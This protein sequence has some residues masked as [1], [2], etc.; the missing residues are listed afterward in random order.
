MRGRK[1]LRGLVRA[2][3]F[4][5]L[6]LVLMI[7]VLWWKADWD[8]R[9]LLRVLAHRESSTTDFRWK[10]SVTVRPSDT[11]IPW[12]EVPGCPHVDRAFA[13]ESDVETMDDYLR[14][15]GTTA[16]VI[17]RH[18][19]IVCEWYGNGGSRAEPAAAM[20][21]SKSVLALLLARA[22]D[23]GQLKLSDPIT[24]FIPRLAARDPRFA[25]ITLA[26][27]VDMKSGIGYTEQTSFPWVN[28]DGP[29]IYY[30]SDLAHTVVE[31]PTISSSPGPFLYNDYA[32]NLTGLALQRATGRPLSVALQDLWNEL[33]AEY[34]AAWSVDE[35][36]FAYHE[37]GFVVTARDLARFGQLLLDDGS[38]H[39]RQV[40]PDAFLQRS[41][42]PVGHEQIATSAGVEVGYRNGWWVLPRIGE[43]DIDLAAMGRYGQ[44]MLVS[45]ADDTV[46][47]R[48]GADGHDET[49]I[50][51]ATRLQRI[52]DR[53]R[54]GEL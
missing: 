43:A 9:Y 38:A 53:L 24:A 8:M 2:I 35:L 31:R 1:V 39:E 12:P 34:P 27:L 6:A 50:S 3:R 47:V 14:E 15:S 32:P 22:V 17:V 54:D 30:A 4:G 29:S 44:I 20:S 45:P 36:G 37:S 10:H 13:A 41:F 28:Q 33:G 51:I 52:S 23:S 42:D 25:N 19:A 26:D 49:N 40:A 5:I 7:T 21:V 16:L 48:M 18:G 46:I 11:S